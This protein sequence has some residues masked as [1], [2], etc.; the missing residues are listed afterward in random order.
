MGEI[1]CDFDARAMGR[2]FHYLVSVQRL[3][4]PPHGGG[5]SLIVE[6]DME[7]NFE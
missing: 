3:P 5:N 7:K 4:Y 2:G 1:P 6:Y